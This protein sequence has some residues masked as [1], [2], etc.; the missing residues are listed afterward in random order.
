[1]IGEN[2][3]ALFMVYARPVAAVS[4]ILDRGRLWF[5]IVAALAVSMMVHI[6][7]PRFSQDVAIP[8]AVSNQTAPPDFDDDNAPVV[9]P[10][11][12]PPAWMIALWSWIAAEPGG[13]FSSPAAVALVFIPVIVF[14]RAVTGHGSFSVLMRSEY[15]SLLMCLLMVWAAAYLP[16]AVILWLAGGMLPA[17]PLLAASN[18]YFIVLAALAIRTAQGVNLAPAAALA[19]LGSAGGVLGL[20]ISD[21]AGPMKYYLMSPFLLYYGYTLFASDVRSL[22]DGLRS[23]QHF[24]QQLEIATSNP[25]DADAHYQLGLIY[26]KRRQWTEAIAR[27]ERAV[28]I[29]PAE[30]D[31]HFQLGRIA[32]AQKRFEDAIGH[33]KTAAG[34]DDKLS[35]SD[36]WRDLGAAYFESGMVEDAASALA[37]YTGRR[38]YDPEGLYWYGRALA[39]LGRTG[40]AREMFERAIEAVKTMPSHRRAEVR[41][42]GSQSKGELKKIA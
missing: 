23:R 1:M 33:L 27:F 7:Q 21:F 4:R 24:Q 32:R 42:W 35:Q 15:L 34:L 14:A 22:G 40:E 12:R 37:K 41:T 38:G 20:T 17:V 28:E 39:S 36:V 2:V 13:F 11:S 6:P 9:P 25:R 29:D 26:Q 5:A 31:P 3:A 16:A 8:A 18:L 10:R 30:A 19:V